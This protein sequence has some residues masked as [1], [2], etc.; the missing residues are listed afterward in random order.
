MPWAKEHKPPAFCSNY[1]SKCSA[2]GC[3][4]NV[5]IFSASHLS[6]PEELEKGII[7]PRGA[8]SIA[9]SAV[10]ADFDMASVC[11]S[12]EPKTIFFSAYG[13]KDTEFSLR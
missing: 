3:P 13:D 4:A 10:C 1:L 11:V 9:M 2:R 7:L 6:T 8:V 12:Y 5:L